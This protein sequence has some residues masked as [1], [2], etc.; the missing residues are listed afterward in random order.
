MFLFLFTSYVLFLLLVALKLLMPY[1]HN[2]RSGTGSN[3]LVPLSIKISMP[4]EQTNV[5]VK[6][7]AKKKKKEPVTKM[8]RVQFGSPSVGTRSKK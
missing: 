1:M 8:S 5:P 3:Q 6:V 2:C 7:R 4:N